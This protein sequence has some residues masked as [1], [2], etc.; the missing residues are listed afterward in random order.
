MRMPSQMIAKNPTGEI[1]PWRTIIHWKV[2]LEWNV[3]QVA[4]CGKDVPVV[5]DFAE[6]LDNDI[7]LRVIN[8]HIYNTIAHKLFQIGLDNKH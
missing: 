5:D 3:T 2:G 8:S 4:L 6:A 1:I 7:L